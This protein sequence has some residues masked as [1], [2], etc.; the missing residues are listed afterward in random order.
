MSRVDEAERLFVERYSCSQAVFA[1]FAPSLGVETSQALQLASALGGGLRAGS[2]CGAVVGALLTLGL[3]RCDEA[4]TPESRHSV[5]D[6]VDTF[7]SRFLDRVGSLECPGI[8]GYDVRIPEERE[9]VHE[10]GLRDSVCLPAVRVAAE[11]L[12]E[13][14]DD[15]DTSRRTP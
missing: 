8:L 1:A 10:R 5:M 7:H 14:L 15:N 4:C 9:I 12:E 3:A 2:A 6:A 13:L 11:I